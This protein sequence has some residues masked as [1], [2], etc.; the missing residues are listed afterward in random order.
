M[1]SVWSCGCIF[2]Q[3]LLVCGHS[4][5]CVLHHALCT[6]TH[7]H[8]HTHTNKDWINMQ[9]HARTEF[10]TTYFNCHLPWSISILL[11]QSEGIFPCTNDTVRNATCSIAHSIICTRLFRGKMHSDWFNGI[12]ILQG[13]W[14]NGE[15]MWYC[16]PGRLEKTL[17]KWDIYV[18][19][20][21][22]GLMYL[23]WSNFICCCIWENG[24]YHVKC[25]QGL[26]EIKWNVIWHC[27]PL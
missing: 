1:K 12:E 8:T 9:P 21:T 2:I 16:Y 25:G 7:T 3:S 10:I 15:N 19:L 20:V 4:A 22:K 13:R 24:V 18:P 23:P 26:I 11:N 14:Q 6:D 27:S 5:R 17:C